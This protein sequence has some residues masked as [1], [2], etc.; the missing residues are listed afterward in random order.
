MLYVRTYFIDCRNFNFFSFDGEN[1]HSTENSKYA[2]HGNENM[3]A[4]YRDK[5]LATG[6]HDENGDCSFKTEI[7]DM[8]TLTWSDGPDY[9]YGIK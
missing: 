9:P 2:H 1:F 7:M 5:A 8:T 4:N 6:C 3:L